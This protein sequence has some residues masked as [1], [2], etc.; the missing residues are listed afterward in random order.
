MGQSTNGQICYGILLEEEIELPWD[1]EEFDGNEEAW[2][3]TVNDYKPLHVCFVSD[4]YA[5][6]FGSTDPRVYEQW[7]HEQAWLKANP[8]PFEMVNVCSG[9]NPIWII[10]SPGTFTSACRGKPLAITS[11]WLECE[12]MLAGPELEDF[13]E[14]HGIEHEDEPK[15]YLSSYWG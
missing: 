13:C 10:A 6:G 8:L 3:R 5:P 7:D 4:N 12:K 9:S 1:K 14:K 2:W 15:W 11:E